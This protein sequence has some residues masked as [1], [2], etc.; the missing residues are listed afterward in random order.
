MTDSNT[1]NL[2]AD[3]FIE[4]W[5]DGDLGVDDADAIVNVDTD[6]LQVT[7]ETMDGPVI[8]SYDLSEEL[9]W[10]PTSA[11]GDGLEKFNILVGNND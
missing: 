10:R 4:Y 11:G 9:C 8:M 1:Q 7:Y 3:E 2:T 5:Q 6:T